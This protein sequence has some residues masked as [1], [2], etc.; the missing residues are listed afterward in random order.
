M[1]RIRRQILRKA[2]RGNSI[3]KILIVNTTCKKAS[4]GKI[5]YGLYRK[6]IEAGDECRLAYGNEEEYPGE[7]DLIPITNHREIVIHNRISFVTGYEGKYSPKATKRLISIIKDF[8]PDIVQLYN[9]HGYYLNSFDLLR[10]LKK[11][12]I[13]TVYS[14]LD[15]SPYLGVCCYAFDCDKFKDGCK[16]C[17][18]E[19][20][21]YPRS[22]FFRVGR[23]MNILK[24]EIYDDFDNLVFVGPQ[25]VKDRALE[26]SLLADK[27]IEI[28]D[29][30]IDTEKCFYPR[31]VELLR[32]K[33][34]ITE[35]RIVILNVGPS[36]DERKG[37]KYFIELARM[38]ENKK[39]IF[40]NVGYSSIATENL[41]ENF[42]PISFV[43][44]Q[45]E[46][47][48]YYSLADLLICTSIADTMPNVCL[49]SLACGTPVAGFRITGI[50][51]VAEEPL[52]KFVTPKDVAA[53]AKL[54]LETEKKD[55]AL[56]EKARQYALER[57]S[58]KIYYEKMK[59]IYNKMI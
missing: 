44:D 7:P 47:A 32:K 9:L 59:R 53:L 37:I 23:Q 52:G 24:K 19:L 33:L 18:K 51:Y 16:N 29:E 49:D 12:E 27:K 36:L 2:K 20:K 41:P 46:L 55:S 39:Y 40:I 58:P 56:I 1:T 45:N 5:A 3:M 15:E 4:T 43:K 28:V 8:K 48:E 10:Y 13:P 31:E 50:P 57:Y 6:L 42:I 34:G 22:M 14:M 25:W 54:V 30:F 17:K 11:Q 21:Q 38:I 35:K 26:S